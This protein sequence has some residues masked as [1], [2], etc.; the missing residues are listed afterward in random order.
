MISFSHFDCFLLQLFI[1]QHES[2]EVNKNQIATHDL[3][4]ASHEALVQANIAAIT[5]NLELINSNGLRIDANVNSI[6][7][8]VL[9]IQAVTDSYNLFRANQVGF[10]GETR[11]GNVN[12]Y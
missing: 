10:Y 2:I 12:T 8:N 11:F 3:T 5:S 7:A 4:L 9:S 6:G 1:E